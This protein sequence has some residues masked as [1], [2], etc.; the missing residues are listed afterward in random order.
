MN[1][2]VEKQQIDFRWGIPAI[3]S[4]FT[5]IPNFL[6]RHYAELGVTPQE[7]ALVIH[8]AS[9]H[10]NSPRGQACPSVG[11]LAKEMGFSTRYVQ[12]IIRSL[13]KKGYLQVTAR[14]GKSSVY[15]MQGL[16]LACLK[17]EKGTDQGSS[18]SSTPESEFTP[19]LHSS[20]LNPSSPHP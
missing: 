14:P 9:Y 15:S 17:I 16:S 10:Y 1:T 13:E 8:L 19:E 11:T 12:I 18:S 2:P 5:T 3:D 4:G 7:F 6:L 20:P